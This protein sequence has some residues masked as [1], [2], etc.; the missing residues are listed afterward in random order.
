MRPRPRTPRRGVRRTWQAVLLVLALANAP[1]AAR[2]ATAAVSPRATPTGSVIDED[3]VVTCDRALGVIKRIRE[4]L[5]HRDAQ[6]VDATTVTIGLGRDTSELEAI[7]TSTSDAILPEALQD[8]SDAVSAYATGA[9]DSTR[10]ADLRAVAANAV[11]GFAKVC[12]VR[13]GG[14][15]SGL[16]GW[17]VTGARLGLIPGSHS[18]AFAGR[19]TSV[20]TAPGEATLKNAVAKT[21]PKGYGFAVWVRSTAPT[22]MTFRLTEHRGAEVLGRTQ[23]STAVDTVWRAVTLSY[24]VV[25][26]GSSLDVIVVQT[27]SAAGVTLDIDDVGA[28]HR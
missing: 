27:G 20:S 3:S 23:R 9:A 5:S 11:S 16:T 24:R 22:R 14:F 8:V 18:G 25:A 17:S 13:N 12:P 4:T 19:L 7:S 1:A 28:V 21:F 15:E 2:I 10:A 6:L 26:S